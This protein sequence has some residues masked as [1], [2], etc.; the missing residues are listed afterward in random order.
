VPYAKGTWCGI[1][2]HDPFWEISGK[3]RKDKKKIEMK[4]KLERMK[5]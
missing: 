3:S 5:S 1:V 2:W 4:R